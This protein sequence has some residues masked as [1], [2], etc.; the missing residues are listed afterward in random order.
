MRMNAIR[1]LIPLAE[2]DRHQYDIRNLKVGGYFT[3]NGEQFQILGISRYQ[4][5]NWKFTKDKSWEVWELQILSL[6][7]A[8]VR[9]VEWA[10]DDELEICLSES[11]L[12]FRDLTDEDNDRIG[13]SD[14]DRI[15]DREGGVI[16]QGKTYWYDNEESWAAKYYKDNQGD[17]PELVR[18]Y[19][20]LSDDGGILTI[21]EWFNDDDCEYEIWTSRDVPTDQIQILQLEGVNQS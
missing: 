18:F 6:K 2:A 10:I 12:T 16:Y 3:Y 21:E 17:D 19:E 4:G 20:F 8:E 9:F 13:K 1:G 5:S 7:T 14:L 15:V 11:R